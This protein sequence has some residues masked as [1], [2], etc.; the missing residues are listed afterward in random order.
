MCKITRIRFER[1]CRAEVPKGKM[2]VMRD[3]SI[4]KSEYVADQKAI[5]KVQ[6]FQDDEVLFQ[7]CE[8]PKVSIYTFAASLLSPLNI[9]KPLICIIN[10]KKL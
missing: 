5:T 8:Y 1:I 10:F 7:Y 9:M 6:N 2:T 3:V 4:A